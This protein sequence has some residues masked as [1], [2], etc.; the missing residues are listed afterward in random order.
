MAAPYYLAAPKGD[1]YQPSF[2]ER[3]SNGINNMPSESFYNLASA[4]ATPG[5]WAQRLTTGL[6]GFGA[7]IA[8][9]KKKQGL[10]AAF[11]RLLPTIPEAQRPIFAE[12]VKN[13]PQALMGAL[14]AQMFA[15]PNEPTSDIQNYQFAVQ[16]GFPG[17]YFDFKK[18]LAQAQVT[19]LGVE[20]PGVGTIDP[21]TGAPM[22]PSAP[23]PQAMPSPSRGAPV[24]PPESVIA[25]DSPGQFFNPDMHKN[26]LGDGMMP[27][28]MQGPPPLNAADFPPAPAPAPAPQYRP[29]LDAQAKI[30][31]LGAAPAGKQWVYGADNRPMLQAVAGATPQQPTEAQ[32][33][34]SQYLTEALAAADVLNNPRATAEFLNAGNAA[35]R[36]GGDTTSFLQSG[37]SQAYYSAAATWAGNFLY[38]KSGAQISPSEFARAQVQYIPKWGDKPEVIAQKAFNRKVA[39]TGL[40]NT[41]TPEQ[42]DKVLK[43]VSGLLKGKN[44]LVNYPAPPPAAINELRL[45]KDKAKFDEVFGPGAA[46]KYLGGK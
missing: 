19:P 43:S 26:T 33:K 8:A 10:A 22:A 3:L 30:L 42:Q 5:P 40:M 34:G 18:Q 35:V 17:T 31:N 27:P 13:D 2:S 39:E 32:A 41:L 15:K 21:K 6:A 12:M 24:P 7:P 25:P 28:E 16:Q 36:E 9:Q 11:D 38:Q 23:P 45:R 29:I 46:D 14:S 1:E 4:L 44:T 37:P 20:V